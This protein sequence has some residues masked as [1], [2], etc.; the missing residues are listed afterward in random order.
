MALH[1]RSAGCPGPGVAG[2]DLAGLSPELLKTLIGS[3]QRIDFAR[4]PR[5]GSNNWT[6]S[7]ALTGERQAAACQ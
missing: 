3:D 4:R 6:I 2:L 7:G 5:E 1:S